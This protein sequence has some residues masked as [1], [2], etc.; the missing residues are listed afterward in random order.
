[1]LGAIAG[2]GLAEVAA[3]FD[4]VCRTY[5]GYGPGPAKSLR[6]IS[7][8]SLSVDGSTLSSQSRY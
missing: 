8:N 3:S 6:T 2:K 4:M 1:M 7:S 5:V